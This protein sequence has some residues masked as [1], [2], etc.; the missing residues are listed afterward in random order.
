MSKKSRSA[1]SPR[2]NQGIQRTRPQAGPVT[3]AVI[4]NATLLAAVI[5]GSDRINKLGSG[6]VSLTNVAAFQ[7]IVTVGAGTL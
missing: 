5:S 7:G 2:G 6:S 1:S 3:A 4:D